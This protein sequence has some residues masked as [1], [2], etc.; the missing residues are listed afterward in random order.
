M[1]PYIVH[2]VPY[3]VELNGGEKSLVIKLV[4]TLDYNFTQYIFVGSEF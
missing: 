3:V 1:S 4:I 2:L